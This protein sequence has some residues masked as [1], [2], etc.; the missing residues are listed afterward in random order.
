MPNVTTVQGI[1]IAIG[2]EMMQAGDIAVAAD[3]CCFC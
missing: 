2:M 1:T 3:G